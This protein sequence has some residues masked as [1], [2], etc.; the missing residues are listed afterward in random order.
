M[1]SV[2]NKT[3]KIIGKIFSFALFIF[4][5]IYSTWVAYM[6]LANT[7]RKHEVCIVA[8]YDSIDYMHY[9][10]GR[11]RMPNGIGYFCF[12]LDKN[13]GQIYAMRGKKQWFEENFPGGVS[14]DPNGVTITAVEFS[15]GKDL[16][17]TL[18]NKWN[19]S[20]V[21]DANGAILPLGLK[22]G[23]F[24]LLDS[25]IA[26]LFSLIV[27]VGS[28]AMLAIEVGFT[29]SEIRGH[30]NEDAE[31]GDGSKKKVHIRAYVNLLVII[32]FGISM[33]YFTGRYGFLR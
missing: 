25:E 17:N 5:F 21:A 7:D 13:S 32:G 11:R 2:W 16:T 23:R 10:S 27:A 30:D 3:K 33:L 20:P 9:T 22:E 14:K 15:A 26:L 19:S 1:V 29:I 24:L 12:G 18:K 8:T 28:L 4:F 6:L 31:E